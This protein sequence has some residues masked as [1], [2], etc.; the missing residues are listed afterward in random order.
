M[1]FGNREPIQPH[2]I[3][4]VY[5]RGLYSLIQKILLIPTELAEATMI[6]AF[7]KLESK[8]AVHW[9]ENLHLSPQLQQA[10]AI[11]TLRWRLPCGEIPLLMALIKLKEKKD[12][13]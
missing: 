4:F 9:T 6:A 1:S 11:L 13:R 3:I 2:L 7:M 10:G 8:L 5:P 12:A